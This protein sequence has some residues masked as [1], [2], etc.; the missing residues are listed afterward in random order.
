MPAKLRSFDGHRSFGDLAPV[1]LSPSS[2]TLVLASTAQAA[3]SFVVLGLPAVGPELRHTYGLSLPELGAVLAAGP[4]G[5]GAALILAGVAVDRFGYR[6]STLGGSVL[7]MAGLLLCALMHAKASLVVGLLTM[8]AGAAVIPIAGAGA[9]FRAYPPE[10][11]GSALGVRQMAVPL[12]GTIAA[13]SFPSLE[14]AGGIGLVFFVGAAAVG[15]VGLAFAAV[16]GTAVAMRRPERP[17][18]SIWRAPSMQRL[19]VVACFYVVVLQAVLAYTVPAVRAA[20]FSAFAAGATYF[21]VNVTAMVSRLVWGRIADRD[22][23]TRRLRTLIEIGVVAAIGAVMFAFA[24]HLD[25]IAVIFAA[26]LFGFGAFGWNALVYAAAGE[27]GHPD[28]A[29]RAFAVAATLVF[30]LG[31]VVTPA[32]GALA[33]RAGWD[34]LWVSTAMVSLMGALV[35]T[36]LPKARIID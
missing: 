32:L 9:I 10:R 20:G 33:Q 12:G 28:L 14:R 21:S 15:G 34:V 22:R 30:A 1:R 4:F 29:A 7:A 31:A 24:L 23:G 8:G 16:S 5:S 19:L 36:T 17:F 27:S 18:R 3:V 13:L 35:A 2:T 26:S 6:A 11:R 25:M